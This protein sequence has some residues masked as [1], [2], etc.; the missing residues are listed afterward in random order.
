MTWLFVNKRM[1]NELHDLNARAHLKELSAPR[2]MNSWMPTFTFGIPSM[3]VSHASLRVFRFFGSSELCLRQRFSWSHFL[4]KIEV[5]YWNPAGPYLGLDC[6]ILCLDWCQTWLR[7]RKGTTR[8][9]GTADLQSY[10]FRSLPRS[11]CVFGRFIQLVALSW[12]VQTL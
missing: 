10:W 12:A 3:D 1:W 5:D 2:L 9:L 7:L 11:A 8:T 6:A 4:R